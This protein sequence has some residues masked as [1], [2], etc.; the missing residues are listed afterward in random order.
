LPWYIFAM[1][2]A[3]DASGRLVVPKALREALDLKPGQVLEVTVR[4]GHLEI[5]PVPA[6]LRFEESNGRL[7]AVPETPMP[8][9]DAATVR[10]VLEKVR[11]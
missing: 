4:D 9:L 11:R 10:D 1:Q 2:A 8:G 5:A 3:I 7:V 6:K